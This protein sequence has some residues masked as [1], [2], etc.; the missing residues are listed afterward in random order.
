DEVI[1]GA[2]LHYAFSLIKN[3]TVKDIQTFINYLNQSAENGNSIAQ[4]NL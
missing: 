4:Y 1:A 3:K 2:Q